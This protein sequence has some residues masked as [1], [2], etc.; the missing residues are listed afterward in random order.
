MPSVRGSSAVQLKH[1]GPS[2]HLWGWKQ[3]QDINSDVTRGNGSAYITGNTTTPHPAICCSPFL[4]LS[5]NV[6][7]G[8]SGHT[9]RQARCVMGRVPRNCP[10]PCSIALLTLGKLMNPNMQNELLS[11]GALWQPPFGQSGIRNNR[12]GADRAKHAISYVKGF[13]TRNL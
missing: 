7:R 1:P 12:L 8:R 2:S 13:E 9:H 11:K 6:P 10:F 5:P 4:L 3:I